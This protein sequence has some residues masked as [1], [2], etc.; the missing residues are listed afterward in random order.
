MGRTVFDR[1][2]AK[3]RNFPRFKF[4]LAI[5]CLLLACLVGY[6]DYLTG[7][8]RSLLLFYLLPISLAAWFG[9][10]AFGLVGAVIAQ[11][12]LGIFTILKP[13]NAMG[14]LS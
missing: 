4:F 5:A 10:L 13:N 9:S 7:Y 1:V 3:L 14:P 12:T 8:E 11:I 2:T 6:V